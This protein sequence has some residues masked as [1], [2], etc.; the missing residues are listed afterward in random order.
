MRLVSGVSTREEPTGEPIH[1]AFSNGP[2]LLLLTPPLLQQAVQPTPP[3]EQTTV[4][5]DSMANVDGC[6]ATPMEIDYQYGVSELNH[7]HTP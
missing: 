6:F 3:P 7:S 4:T 5:L 2:P 1:L